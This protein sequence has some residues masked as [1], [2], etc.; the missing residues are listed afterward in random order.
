MTGRKGGNMEE[1]GTNVN[2]SKTESQHTCVNSDRSFTLP[3][4]YM[5]IEVI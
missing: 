4:T 3:Y 1:K 5:G 2:I